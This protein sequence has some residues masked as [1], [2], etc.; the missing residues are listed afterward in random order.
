[1]SL[2]ELGLRKPPTLPTIGLEIS[3]SLLRLKFKHRLNIDFEHWNNAWFRPRRFTASNTEVLAVWI[4][5]CPQ[6]KASNLTG[7]RIRIHNESLSFS[8]NGAAD[9]ANSTWKTLLV[10]RLW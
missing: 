5:H 3:D 1:V 4:P 9:D 8:K 7:K 10:H 6:C 2:S